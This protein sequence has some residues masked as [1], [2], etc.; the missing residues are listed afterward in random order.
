M[1]LSEKQL[2][3]VS[4]VTGFIGRFFFTF[5]SFDFFLTEPVY[6]SLRNPDLD[7]KY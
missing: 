4:Y 1:Y 6:H 2:N 5:L 7:G 3:K